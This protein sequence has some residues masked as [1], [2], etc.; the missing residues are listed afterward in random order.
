MTSKHCFLQGVLAGLA[1]KQRGSFNA[2]FSSIQYNKEDFL[3]GFAVGLLSPGYLGDAGAAKEIVTGQNKD[4]RYW[5]DEATRTL[6]LTEYSGTGKINYTWNET[7]SSL[8]AEGFSD[9][10]PV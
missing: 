8:A 10:Y 2:S 9:N 6:H 5:F 4:I 7:D 1:I 3:S